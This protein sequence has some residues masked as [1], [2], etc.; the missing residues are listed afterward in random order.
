MNKWVTLAILFLI[1][2][3]IFGQD[4]K[5]DQLEVLYSQV[6]YKKV[7]RKANKLLAIPDYDYSGMPTFYKSLATFRLLENEDWNQKNKNGLTDA[8]SLYNQFLEHKKRP[9]YIRA[10]YFEIAELKQFLIDLQK[11]NETENNTSDAQKIKSFIEI[12]LKNITSSGVKNLKIISSNN[13]IEPQENSG[14]PETNKGNAVTTSVSAR[15]EMINYASTFIG[16][17]YQWAGST[18]KGFDC[19]GYVG[20]VFANYGIP[21]PRTA[22]AL[23]TKTTPIDDEEA[24]KGDLVFFKTG[25][26][27]THVGIVISNKGEPLTM[28]HASSSKGIIKT[29]VRTSTYWSKKYAGVG[30]ILE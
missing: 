1:P 13:K 17:P 28:L 7:L 29:N 24:M 16:T 11:K 12:Q 2:Q 10:H 22:A 18:P 25:S 21:V 5:I 3:I 20:Y 23:K 8:I 27:I 14:K 6:H 4:K 30:R 9:T 26:K 19:S 15:D